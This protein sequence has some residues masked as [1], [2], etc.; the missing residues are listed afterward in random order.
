MYR[1][2]NQKATESDCEQR[3]D[4]ILQAFKTAHLY[5]Y[6]DFVSLLEHWKPEILNSFKRP[7]DTFRQSNA[8]SENINGKLGT[9]I[10]ISN[11]LSNFERFRARAIYCLNHKISYSLTSHIFRYNKRIGNP[12]GSYKKT[13]DSM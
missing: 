2:F 10:R 11:G 6:E 5:C 7:Y 13:K 4:Q 8:L 12:R 3:F 1:S 9:L